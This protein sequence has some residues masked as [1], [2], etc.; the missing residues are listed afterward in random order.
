MSRPSEPVD[1]TSMSWLAGCSPRRITEPLP[2]CFSI[3]LSAAESAFLRLLSSMPVDPPSLVRL[4]HNR[5]ASPSE[6]T[7]TTLKL[8]RGRFFM[9][10]SLTARLA[11]EAT[12]LHG[13]F[14]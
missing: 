7:S 9:S 1:T 5:P 8:S 3:W 4:F 13:H 6:N 14:Q 12:Y 2:N 11:Q 10:D